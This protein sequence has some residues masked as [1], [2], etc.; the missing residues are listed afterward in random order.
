VYRSQVITCDRYTYDDID[1]PKNVEYIV[2][3][4]S[5]LYDKVGG[6]DFIFLDYLSSITCSEGFCYKAIKTA[7][8]RLRENGMIAVHDVLE[9]KYNV[10]KALK[11]FRKKNPDAEVIIFPYGFGLALIRKAEPSKYGKLS[12]KSVKKNE[13]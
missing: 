9:G 8:S 3:K 4:P 2:G 10:N 6:I 12:P 11:T 1:I 7:Y 13:H 5:D